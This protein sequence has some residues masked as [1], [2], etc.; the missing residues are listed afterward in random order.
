MSS[1]EAE[2]GKHEVREEAPYIGETIRDLEDRFAPK[3]D[4]AK[5]QL[6][7]INSKVKGFIKE[8]PGTTLLAAVGLGYIIGRLASRR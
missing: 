1:G 5:Q 7:Q 4:E 2:K 3:L 8:N 6:S